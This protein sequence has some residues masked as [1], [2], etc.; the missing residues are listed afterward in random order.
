MVF[1]FIAAPVLSRIQRRDALRP[2]EVARR[3]QAVHDFLE[4]GLFQPG[5]ETP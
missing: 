4:H 5:A 2:Q 3:R 1:Y